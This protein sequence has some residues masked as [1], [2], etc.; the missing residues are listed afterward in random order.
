MMPSP[1]AMA[2]PCGGCAMPSDMAKAPVTW[3]AIRAEVLRRIQSHVWYPGA[4]IPNEAELA[5]EFGCARS[6]VSRA[7]R[8]I[9]ATGLLERRR[10]AGTRVALNP[11]RRATFEIPVIQHEVEARGSVYGYA[12][13][14]RS[15]GAAPP[16]ICS[17]MGFSPDAALLHLRAL[18]MADG[19]PYVFE[20][21]WVDPEVVPGIL[22]VD[23]ARSSANAWLVQNMPYTGG[24][25][26]LCA[27]SAGAE[28]ATRLKCTPDAAIFTMERITHVCESAI[29]LVIQ[30]YAP[31]Y[32]VTTML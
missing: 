21:R 29:T 17:R 10:K 30:S 18:H 26:T 9:A 23:L 22:T 31:G 6:T 27:Q 14:S 13:I 7:L 16:E 1:G 24:S 28:L 20:N 15:L 19:A 4:Q 3:Q 11:A 32:R 2:L 12:L 8:E 25:L 5:L